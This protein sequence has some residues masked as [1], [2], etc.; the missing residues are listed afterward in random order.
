MVGSQWIAGGMGVVGLNFA[1]IAVMCEAMCVEFDDRL[2]R[3][4]KVIERDVLAKMEHDM[5]KEK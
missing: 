4:L 2:I 5:S 3:K 1:S